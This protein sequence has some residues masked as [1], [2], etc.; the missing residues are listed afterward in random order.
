MLCQGGG[1]YDKIIWF[2]QLNR[3]CELATTKSLNADVSSV[4]IMSQ[5]NTKG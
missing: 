4:R 1:E 5:R 3:S 2:Y